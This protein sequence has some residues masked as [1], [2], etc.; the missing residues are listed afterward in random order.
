MNSKMRL[1]NWR[2]V[3]SHFFKISN[4]LGCLSSCIDIFWCTELETPT[5]NA[6]KKNHSKS[7]NVAPSN[8]ADG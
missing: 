4:D 1:K 8:R 2:R 6:K 7:F 3:R 5:S